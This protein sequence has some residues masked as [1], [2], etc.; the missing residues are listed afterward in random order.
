VTRGRKWQEDQKAR[1]EEGLLCPREWK[2]KGKTKRISERAAAGKIHATADLISRR[3]VDVELTGERHSELDV[4]RTRPIRP[5]IL[6]M[7]NLGCLGF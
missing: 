6:Y 2:M 7:G 5:G 4:I 3:I 1:E